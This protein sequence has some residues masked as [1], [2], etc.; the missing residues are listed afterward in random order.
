MPA[1]PSWGGADPAEVAP[2]VR[3]SMRRVHLAVRR[4]RQ[5]PSMD[6]LAWDCRQLSGRH[7]TRVSP[8]HS[9]SVFSP[10][11]ALSACSWSLALSGPGKPLP[12]GSPLHPPHRRWGCC[13]HYCGAPDAGG[14]RL[15]AV[16]S[17]TLATQERSNCLACQGAWYIMREGPPARATASGALP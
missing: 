12:R 16:V 1:P 8:S 4:C 2:A 11:S 14:S 10:C 17:P 7:G 6:R 13:M 5:R 9:F 15:Q 3:L